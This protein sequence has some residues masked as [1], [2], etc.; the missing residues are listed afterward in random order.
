MTNNINKNFNL[1]VGDKNLEV[2]VKNLAEQANGNVLVRYG[3]TEVLATCVMSKDDMDKGF[4]PLTV[5]Y[6][7]RFYAAGKIRGARYI[8]RES[9][10]SDEAILNARFIDRSIRPLF[11]KNLKK[12]IQVVITVLSWDAANDPDFV[13][14]LAASL[15]LSI[16]DIPWKGPLSASRV[17]KKE[18]SFLINPTYAERENS[19]GEIIFASVKEKGE[20][21]INMME[22]GFNQVDD[23]FIPDAFEFA[24]KDLENL[25]YFSGKEHF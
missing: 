13:G 11:P 15:A 14:I 19:Q 10:P 8:R 2:I 7:E 5:D 12:G 24:K 4:F 25:F 18:D 20:L 9:R 1:K 23:N 17:A 16:S 21:L 22:G 6:E 3:D